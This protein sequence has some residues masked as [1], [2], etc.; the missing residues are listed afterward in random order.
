MSRSGNPDLSALTDLLALMV[1][2]RDPV[3][4][5][6][7]D[8]VQTFQSLAPYALEEA[9]EVVDAIES[10]G[11]AKLREELGDLLF[12]VVFHAQ[13]AQERGWFDFNAIAQAIHD[14]LV[15]R[16]PHVFGAQAGASGSANTPGEVLVAWEE[17]KARERAAAAADKDPSGTG[18]TAGVLAEVP[19][20][21]PALTRAQKLGKRA[22]RVGFDWTD[23]R[24]VRAKI[25]EEL[26]EL[27]EAAL[28]AR[29]HAAD[30]AGPPAHLVEEMGDLLFAIANWGRHVGADAESALRA[31]NAKFERRF[32]S[33]ETLA[34]ER[35]LA[36]TSLSLEAWEALWQ[37]AKRV[38]RGCP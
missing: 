6:P 22:G 20:A 12:Q 10:G 25:T 4:G 11:P 32:A 28:E 19:R 21:L 36:L 16:H 5:C 14:K 23:M 26:A 35:A 9:Y 18:V 7:W 1:K 3:S 30:S 27:D 2:L 34:R 37:E 15:R 38:E 33:M 24:D 13:L 8:R 17:L 31:A 29:E